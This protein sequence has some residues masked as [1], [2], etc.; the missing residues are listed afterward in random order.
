MN[1]NGKL[2]LSKKGTVTTNPDSVFSS[3]LAIP[4]DIQA[5]LDERKL[6]AR[7]IDGKSLTE[8]YGYH[9]K[10]WIPYEMPEKLRK[11]QWRTGNDPDGTF[12]RGTLVLAVKSTEDVAK[13]KAFLKLRAEQ[14]TVQRHN[15]EEAEKMRHWAKETGGG[16]KIL[17]GY[18]E[19]E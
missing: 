4:K 3:K 13:H 5:D 15:K 18:E 9:A 2:P 6:E 10:D 11:S 17:E 12:R 1:K 19:N 7:W 16:V 8:N 14:S